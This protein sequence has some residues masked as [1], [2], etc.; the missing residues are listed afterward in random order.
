MAVG[1]PHPVQHQL[2]AGVEMQREPIPAG[3][4]GA[5]RLAAPFA[6][7]PGLAGDLDRSVVDR[8]LAVGAI[9]RL[10]VVIRGLVA[11]G[12]LAVA[13]VALLFFWLFVFVFVRF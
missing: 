10:A 7:E 8:K 6:V 11:L 4:G 1:L 5:E 9:E 2:A 3:L 12:L 13:V